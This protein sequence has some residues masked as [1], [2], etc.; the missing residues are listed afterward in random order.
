[1][2]LD[3]DPNYIICLSNTKLVSLCLSII[4]LKILVC[5]NTMN[6]NRTMLPCSCMKH[7]NQSNESVSV[8]MS[9]P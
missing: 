3:D 4:G 8:Q 7:R 6:R 5:L 1:M 9:H 2:D